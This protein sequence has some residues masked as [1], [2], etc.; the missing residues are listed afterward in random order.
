MNKQENELIKQLTSKIKSSNLKSFP[1][2]FISNSIFFEESIPEK[3]LVLGSE[4]FGH[5][6]IITTDGEP[7][8]MVDNLKV[9][10]YYIYSSIKRKSFIKIPKIETD[11]INSVDAYENYFDEI[12]RMIDN[13]IIKNGF[14]YNRFKIT[15]QIIQHLN[16]IRF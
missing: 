9:A 1:D 3:I 12:V 16:L 7:F 4:F 5:Y 13:E 10:K 14:G 11:L 15:N 6:E 8:K 2:D